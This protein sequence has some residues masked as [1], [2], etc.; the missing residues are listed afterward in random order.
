MERST[1]NNVVQNVLIQNNVID[2]VWRGI[3]LLT[4]HSGSIGD[5]GSQGN[6]ME[7]VTI[8]GNAITNFSDDGI[9]LTGGLSGDSLLTLNTLNQVTLHDNVLRAD[10]DAR[11]W[12][13]DFVTGGENWPS[14]PAINNT[15]SGLSI[16]DNTI[17]GAHN[18][19][20][21]LW[22]KSSWGAG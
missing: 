12:F 11:R 19:H 13:R 17:E 4:A 14:G 6:I 5:I 3:I 22:G 20:R 10:D 8:S 16:Y 2:R 9:T 7:N 21:H 1:D 15:V 18:W